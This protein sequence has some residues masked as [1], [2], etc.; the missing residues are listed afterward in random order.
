[1]GKICFQLVNTSMTGHLQQNTI[2]SGKI[3]KLTDKQSNIHLNSV[4]PYNLFFN[5]QQT[6]TAQNVHIKWIRVNRAQ[7]SLFSA[8]FAWK[9]LAFFCLLCHFCCFCF[10]ISISLFINFVISYCCRLPKNRV[11]AQPNGT[12]Q[13]YDIKMLN[14][15]RSWQKKK[16]P[17]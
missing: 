15:I 1:M 11:K 17:I 4:W 9:H 14:R 5:W 3:M 12:D 16:R 10:L 8:D 2:D 6:H 7:R 13:L